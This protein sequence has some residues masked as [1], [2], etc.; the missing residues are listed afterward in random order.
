MQEHDKLRQRLTHYNKIITKWKLKPTIEY[1][2]IIVTTDIFRTS[3]EKQYPQD[4][5]K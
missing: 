1:Q 2:D 5:E 3:A 4:N